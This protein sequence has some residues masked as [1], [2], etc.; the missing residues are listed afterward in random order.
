MTKEE[1]EVFEK[2]W[3]ASGRGNKIFNI[4]SLPRERKIIDALVTKGLLRYMSEKYVKL[5]TEGI[6]LGV[7]ANTRVY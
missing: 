4:M 1:K 3:K 2:I 6:R 5:T 7:K